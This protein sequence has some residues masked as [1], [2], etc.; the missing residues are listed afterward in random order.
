MTW[1]SVRATSVGVKAI[2]SAS[3]SATAERSAL[4]SWGASRTST[5]ARETEVVAWTTWADAGPASAVTAIIASASTAYLMGA[6]KRPGLCWRNCTLG[7]TDGTRAG[8]GTVVGTLF[9]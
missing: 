6:S 2:V 7:A 3:T 5:S 9:A 1:A 8:G 4:S